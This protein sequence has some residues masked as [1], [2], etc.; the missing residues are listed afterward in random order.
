M[1]AAGRAITLFLRD[2]RQNSEVAMRVFLCAG[3]LYARNGVICGVYLTI[4]KTEA[5]FRKSSV[6]FLLKEASGDMPEK[7]ENMQ[8]I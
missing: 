6:S 2:L 3:L 7:Q 1:P 4:R 5:G 8:N